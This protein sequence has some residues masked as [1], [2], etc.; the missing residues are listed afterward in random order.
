[1]SEL[2][3]RLRRLGDELAYPATPDLAAAAERVA[4]SPASSPR[5]R[6]A[7]PLVLAFAALLVLLAGALALSPG[8]RSAFLELF[9][10]KGA[11]VSRVERL[12]E[13][14]L[15]ELDLGEPVTRAEAERRAGFRVHALPGDQPDAIF[16][17]AGRLVTLV[18]GP[19]ERPRLLLSQHRAQVWDGFVKKAAGGRTLV[20]EVQV[21]TEPGLF[22]SGA[23][24]YVL[25]LEDG[26]VR[27][28][29]SSLAGNTLLW[30]RGELLLRLEADVDRDEAIALAESVR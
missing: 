13:T 29:P 28:E 17:R 22:V 11:T 6:R 9:R 8:A 27:E 21:G 26:R 14:R 3:L 12:P 20:E 2:E 30:N 16:L 15:V 10:L 7:R 19:P 25:F 23:E 18:Y 5:R 24:H 1:M 4:S